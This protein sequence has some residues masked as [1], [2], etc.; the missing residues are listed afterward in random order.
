[1]YG[2][3]SIAG[4][5]RE[6]K[7]ELKKEV[8]YMTALSGQNG[9][10]ATILIRLQRVQLLFASALFLLVTADAFGTTAL[11]GALGNIIFLVCSLL[12]CQTGILYWAFYHHCRKSPFREKLK[13]F[14]PTMTLAPLAFIAAGAVSFLVKP[15]PLIHRAYALALF[16]LIP[17]FHLIFRQMFGHQFSR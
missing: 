13:L 14:L 15:F 5:A 8:G 2:I 11:E 12:L 6:A 9:I 10:V 7:D 3:R 1:V 4:P 17:I 16:S